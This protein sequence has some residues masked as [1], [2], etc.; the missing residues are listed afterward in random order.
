M[1]SESSSSVGTVRYRWHPLCGR[2]T[3]CVLIERR[4]SGEIAHLELEPGVITKVAAWKLDPVYCATLK[5]ALRANDDET[6]ICREFN[7]EGLA[8]G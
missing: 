7:L 1:A 3:R 5:V 6:T 4:A 2:S 8:A